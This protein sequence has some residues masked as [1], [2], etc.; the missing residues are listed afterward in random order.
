MKKII[1]LIV[2]IVVLSTTISYAKEIE[3]ALGLQLGNASGN[4]YSYRTIKGDSGFQFVFG[5]MT[6]G[7]NDVKFSDTVYGSGQELYVTKKG[8][9]TSASFGV[10]YLKVLGQTASSRFYL[11][12]GG[13]YLVSRRTEFIQ[14]Y[15]PQ[16]SGSTYGYYEKTGPVTKNHKNRDHWTIGVGP[17]IELFADKTFRL[18]VD[19]PI[20]YNSKSEVI[21][22]I[23]QVGLYY[24]FK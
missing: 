11:I 20:T 24:Y 22:Y 4:G 23:P 3:N 16:S 19:I 5:A 8:R 14:T 7:D 1:L 12:G 17:G 10:S 21:P 9:K 2:S 18:V 13:S 6:S 15:T